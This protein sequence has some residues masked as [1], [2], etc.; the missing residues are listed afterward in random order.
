MK[1]F[2]AIIREVN[3]TQQKINELEEK[4]KQ[5]QNTYL[6]IMDLKER[7]EKRK[8]VEYELIKLEEKKKDLQ[9]TIK[10]LNSN[11]KIALYNEVM[12]QVLEVLAKYKNKPYG[13]KTEQKIRDEIKEKTNCSFY[14]SDRYSSQEYHII[15]LEFSHNYYNIECGTKYIEG[16]QKK[17]LDDNKIQVQELDDL[18]IYYSSKEYIDNIP[19]R[20][21]YLK[22]LYKKAYEKQQEL[23][24][25]CSDYNNLAVGSIKNIYKDKKIYPN[26]DI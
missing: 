24:K 21:K 2:N 17:L 26:M 8:N 19:K 13:P 14:I 18:T 4:T 16:K 9:I 22:R 5:L 25:I 11:A 23:E 6:N 10:I 15:P 12:P 1:K 7:H 20:I 3:Q